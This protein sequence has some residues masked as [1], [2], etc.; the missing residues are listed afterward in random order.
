MVVGL[1]CLGWQWR[2][3]REVGEKVKEMKEGDDRE[4]VQR[5]RKRLRK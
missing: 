5:E 3:R 1:V 2:W 4:V